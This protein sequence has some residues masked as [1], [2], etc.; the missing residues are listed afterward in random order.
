MFVLPFRQTLKSNVQR[1]TDPQTH[2]ILKTC[3]GTGKV[4]VCDVV[5]EPLSESP[6]WW[7]QDVF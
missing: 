6:A 1:T 2:T 7:N 5:R 3:F 4:V